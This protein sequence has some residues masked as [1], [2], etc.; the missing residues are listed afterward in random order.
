MHGK[1]IFMV[2]KNRISKINA[3]TDGIEHYITVTYFKIYIYTQ[4]ESEFIFKFFEFSV[5]KC[6]LRVFKIL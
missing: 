6:S 1:E 3:Y 5:K 4:V 2:I